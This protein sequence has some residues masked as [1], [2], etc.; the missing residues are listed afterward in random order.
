[1]DCAG[2][3]RELR[4]A[5]IGGGS[6]NWVPQ[7][8]TDLALCPDLTSTVSLYDIDLEAAEQNVRRGEAVFSHPDARTRFTVRAHADIE[9][10]LEG[11]DFVIIAIQPGSITMMTDDIDIPKRYGV[12]HAVGDT[13]GPAGT[14]RALRTIPI[15]VGFAHRVMES[16]PDAWVMN[17]TNPMAVCVATL[18][19]AEPEIKAF[20]YC[21]EVLNTQSHL[22]DVVE[23][24]FGEQPED[25]EEIDVEVAGVNHFTLATSAGWHGSD[26]F[27][28]LRER[29]AREDFF[30]DRTERTGT[31]KSEGQWFASE[32]L[33]AYDFLRRFGVFGAAGDRHLAEFVPWYLTS[34]DAL[35]RWGVLLTPSSFRLEKAAARDKPPE[36]PDKLE[37]SGGQNLRQ[38]RA[39]MGLGDLE[40]TT[41]IPNRGQ[42]PNLPP[43]AVLES[44][45]RFRRD[46]IETPVVA[47]L[48]P[49]ASAL[50]QRIIDVHR[51]TLRAGLERDKDLALRAF[52]LDPLM[53]LSTDTAWDMLNDMLRA[54]KDL[55]PGW[56][57]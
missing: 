37:P 11:A 42:V 32:F 35:H 23:E 2:Q 56:D 44:N 26:L 10:A 46:A 5:C 20:G 49:A 31:L 34:E 55:L 43:G 15:Y 53:H 19:E 17:C 36:R 45:V 40:T 16:C 13:A 29:M 30:A 50:Q 18:Y 54:T 57:I 8:M 12:L 7:I 52:L 14:V 48:P 1:M 3:K 28:V 51:A 39:L 6:R 33:V 24:H 22:V 4:L 38:L 21:H 41:N 9:V 25:R 47:P 27:P